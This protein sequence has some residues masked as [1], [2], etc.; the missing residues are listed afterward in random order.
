[1]GQTID[2]TVDIRGL[3]RI[4]EHVHYSEDGTV[5]SVDCKWVGG[6][7]LYVSWELLRALG[8]DGGDCQCGDEFEIGPYRVSVVAVVR[9]YKVV[10]VRWV[11][12]KRRKVLRWVPPWAG[13]WEYNKWN[14]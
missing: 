9:V 13:E 1:M 14:S 10:Q 8:I 12:G 7:T 3:G 5:E 2:V 6:P 11:S 4:E